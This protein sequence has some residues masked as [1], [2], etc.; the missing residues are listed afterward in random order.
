MPEDS[1]AHG[2]C[3]S[4]A[5]GLKRERAEEKAWNDNAFEVWYRERKRVR[6]LSEYGCDDIGDIL[7]YAEELL[8][9]VRLI[10]ESYGSVEAEL[11]RDIQRK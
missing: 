3:E 10:Y 7:T 8:E 2:I 4:F 1:D 5:E 9:S 6:E 11:I